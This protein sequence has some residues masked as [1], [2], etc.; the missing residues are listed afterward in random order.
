MKEKDINL[1]NL[2]E[3][4]KKNKKI[5]LGGGIVLLL[6]LSVTLWYT[7]LRKNDNKP[8]K[9]VLKVSMVNQ[10]PPYSQ[11]GKKDSPNSSKAVNN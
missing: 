7:C 4:I 3:S 1:S 5:W 6:V 2:K 10:C 9:D 11:P 8:K